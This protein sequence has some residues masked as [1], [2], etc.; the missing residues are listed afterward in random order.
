MRVLF[1]YILPPL[2]ALAV[3]LPAISTIT[4]LPRI[5]ASPGFVLMN[6][7]GETVTSESLRGSIVVF[8][9]ASLGCDGGC[10]E[11]LAAM[12][13]IRQDFEAAAGDAGEHPDVRLVTIIVDGAGE[14]ETLQRF[15]AAHGIDDGGWSVLSGS[16]VAV[17]AVV[18]SGFNVQ[19][20]GGSGGQ[21]AVDP[22]VFL[23]DHAGFLRAEYRTSTPQVDVIHADIERILDEAGAGGVGGLFYNAAHSLSLSCGG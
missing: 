9:I 12:K 18:T 11:A 6:Q 2:V 1:M 14:P 15:A 13:R 21:V 5:G 8:S 16:D 7:R 10:S 17:R 4:I 19:L 23:A 22:A 3:V 20:D